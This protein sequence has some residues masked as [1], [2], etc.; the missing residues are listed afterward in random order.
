MVPWLQRVSK[1]VVL[2]LHK[3]LALVLVH[4]IFTLLLIK[5]ESVVELHVEQTVEPDS[6]E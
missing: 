4:V 1:H 3:L 5:L 6:L 2:V